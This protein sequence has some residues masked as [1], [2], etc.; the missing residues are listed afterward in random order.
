[1]F[2]QKKEL[3]CTMH[4]GSRST[5]ATLKP[6]AAW[7][8]PAWPTLDFP[9][10]VPVRDSVAPPTKS[11]LQLAREKWHQELPQ[12]IVLAEKVFALGSNQD[13]PTPALSSDDD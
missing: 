13:L 1:M 2:P 3:T 5:V 7:S 11:A 10:E 9:A 6:T 4:Y 12:R 8:S